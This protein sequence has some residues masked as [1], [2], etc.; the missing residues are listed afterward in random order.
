MEPARAIKRPSQIPESEMYGYTAAAQEVSRRTQQPLD[1]TY[2]ELY[3]YWIAASGAGMT[4]PAKFY[5]AVEQTVI[6]LTGQM[7]GTEG[8][9]RP[10]FDGQ[11]SWQEV[12]MR[13][14]KEFSDTCKLSFSDVS[15]IAI[16]FWN[17]ATDR[18][19]LTDKK[20]YDYVY[21]STRRQLINKCGQPKMIGAHRLDG[22]AYQPIL[23]GQ[24]QVTNW[25][26]AV[27]FVATSS[28][29]GRPGWFQAGRLLAPYWLEA[30]QQGLTGQAQ[31][32][33]ALGKLAEQFMGPGPGGMNGVT[34]PEFDVQYATADE[35]FQP[36]TRDD[37]LSS[38]NNP[39]FGSPTVFQAT[40]MLEPY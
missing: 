24:I 23:P 1:I 10:E 2:R 31:A 39:E 25:Q 28:E 34:H 17:D 8:I 37:W 21:Q 38:V 15:E 16:P 30:A 40:R 13:L 18:Q 14:L 3:P 4:G 32:D 36:T 20:R 9:I 27:Q 19:G 22:L 11:Y 7:D 33:Y 35:F 26:T 6:H 5:F 29:F 12:V